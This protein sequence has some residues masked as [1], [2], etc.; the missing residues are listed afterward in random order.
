MIPTLSP[1]KRKR[2]SSEPLPIP[3]R[4]NDGERNVVRRPENPAS[5]TRPRSRG[6]SIGVV[7]QVKSNVSGTPGTPARKHS[8]QRSPYSHHYQT[9][10]YVLPSQDFVLEE[11]PQADFGTNIGY[12]G[13]DIV[14]VAASRDSLS[15]LV[16]VQRGST[17]Y[18][19]RI[20]FASPEKTNG[21]N[22]PQIE[23]SPRSFTLIKSESTLNQVTSNASISQIN[24]VGDVSKQVH[25]LRPVRVNQ[26]VSI[27]HIIMACGLLVIL[28]AFLTPRSLVP[29]LILF[30]PN[31]ATNFDNMEKGIEVDLIS[32]NDVKE[33]DCLNRNDLLK[34]E[35]SLPHSSYELLRSEIHDSPISAGNCKDGCSLFMD[36]GTNIQKK[37]RISADIKKENRDEDLS[38]NFI[39]FGGKDGKMDEKN[40]VTVVR[41][42]FNDIIKTDSQEDYSLKED[43]VSMGLDD[44]LIDDEIE[45]E[46]ENENDNENE[47]ENE[48][49]IENENE[50]EN[51]NEASSVLVSP[52]AV[53]STPIVFKY[54]R[55][56]AIEISSESILYSTITDR[57][58]SADTFISDDIQST[59]PLHILSN[60]FKSDSSEATPDNSKFESAPNLIKSTPNS[61]DTTLTNF[62]LSSAIADIDSPDRHIPLG[63]LSEL[64]PFVNHNTN[65]NQCMNNSD[66]NPIDNILHD[67]DHVL[68][69][70]LSITIENN[71]SNDSN[72]DNNNDNNDDVNN[73]N[74]D[75]NNNDNN[76][77]DNDDDDDNDNKISQSKLQ[78]EKSNFVEK[79]E[80]K[81]EI[82]NSDN[83]YGLDYAVWPRGG[84][85]VSPGYFKV[86]HG[87]TVLTSS[88]YVLPKKKLGRFEKLK[89][90]FHMNR[91]EA[92]ESIMINH[93][94]GSSGH[95][96]KQN[97]IESEIGIKS[98]IR[99]DHSNSNCHSFAEIISNATVVM[100]A[101][102]RVRAV[103]IVYYHHIDNAKKSTFSSD[104]SK[105]PTSEVSDSTSTLPRVINAASD[106][107]DSSSSPSLSASAPALPEF[108]EKNENIE[109]ENTLSSAPYRF[110]LIG[111]TVDP[112]TNN[113]AKSIHLGTFK[114]VQ[115]RDEEN[116]I[117]TFLLSLDGMNNSLKAVTI[118]VLSNHGM[119]FT[120]ICR[121]RVLGVLV[122]GDTSSSHT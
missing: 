105:V 76:N 39:N 60:F 40:G 88:P 72:N 101:P 95:S 21:Y 56:P 79:K 117:Q 89:Y 47:N 93:D 31:T 116:E 25:Q 66:K 84:R 91:E 8:T 33:D 51:E 119:A 16:V 111:W 103:Q 17:A 27:L 115:P 43:Q 71:D 81:L 4:N 19:T 120:S 41:I 94:K 50:N 34:M 58:N 7:A 74:N 110:H 85:I 20:R 37:N 44:I 12:K 63:T 107:I 82:I 55:R 65:E 80:N 36:T 102:V 61:S 23:P 2:S 35:S 87:V 32:Q 113:K 53:D 9:E 86:S 108:D 54:M 42:S 14:Q 11:S 38:K 106:I 5:L 78:N 75:V 97:K 52:L 13:N 83:S 96:N 15:P 90:Q 26:K 69:S 46:I 59:V 99:G 10:L 109:F 18:R 98:G 62:E 48:S 1:L 64:S 22:R 70:L 49:Q 92:H 67:G 57:S 122:D 3:Y 112:T 114:Y 6:R 24:M 73:D 29:V 28:I 45:I 118:S 121:I 77:N 68:N 104:F 30:R 100:Y